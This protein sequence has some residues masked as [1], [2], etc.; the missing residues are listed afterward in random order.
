MIEQ[1]SAWRPNDVVAYEAMRDAANTAIALLLRLSGDGAILPSQ[2]HSEAASIR[3]QLF[4]VDGYDRD[5]VNA[6]RVAFEE[7][8]ATLSGPL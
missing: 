7:R 6:A 3:R 1:R 5:G 4:Q 2:V 8:I